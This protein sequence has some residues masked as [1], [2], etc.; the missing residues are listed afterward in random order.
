MDKQ[1]EK[2]KEGRAERDRESRVGDRA[3]IL[4]QLVDKAEGRLIKHSVSYKISR[5]L[6]KHIHSHPSSKNII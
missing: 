1:E 5:V 6:S 4:S 3:G 2:E